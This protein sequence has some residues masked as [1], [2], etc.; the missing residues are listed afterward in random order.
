[1]SGALCACDAVFAN[2]I[3][4]RAVVASSTKRRLVMAVNFPGR[5]FDEVLG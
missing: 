5:F 2:C 4:V 3:A 1:M